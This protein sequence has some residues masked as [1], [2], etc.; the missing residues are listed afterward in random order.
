MQNHN[1]LSNLNEADKANILKNI[2]KKLKDLHGCEE[3]TLKNNII[4]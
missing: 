1:V 4:H 2:K 3:E